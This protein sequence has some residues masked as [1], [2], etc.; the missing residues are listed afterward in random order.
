MSHA[1]QPI[2]EL[3]DIMCALRDPEAGCPWDREQTFATIL[4]YTLE[5]AYEVAEAIDAGDKQALKDELGDLLFQVVFY[6]QMAA[7]D[8]D[9]NFD[10]VVGGIVAKMRRR[11]PHVFAGERITDAESQTA[12]WEEIK[13]AEQQNAIADASILDGVNRALPALMRAEKLQKRAS[14]KGFDW[15]D[16]SGALDKAAEELQEL[17][18]AIAEPE[19]QERIAEEL[20]D[21][22]FS[23]VNVARFAQVSPEVAL[24]QANAKFERRFRFVEQKLAARGIKIEEATL[25]EMDALWER[26]K[27]ST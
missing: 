2:Q 18:Q 23:C 12:R 6:A 4:P 3:L 25:A 26:S 22:L 8:G 7:E 19:S 16:A 17:Q 1:D 27:Q 9:F 5:E 14:R 11:H 24:R 21:L 13:A 20:G 10:D 15:P